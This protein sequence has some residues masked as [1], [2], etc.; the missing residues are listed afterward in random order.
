MVIVCN[1]LKLHLYYTKLMKYVFLHYFVK[2]QTTTKY[3]Y[4]LQLQDIIL[5]LNIILLFLTGY[6]DINNNKPRRLSPSIPCVN[7]EV[8]CLEISRSL[9]PNL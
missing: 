5:L 6:Y 8:N 4:N 9:S 2:N 3:H 1:L 7:K